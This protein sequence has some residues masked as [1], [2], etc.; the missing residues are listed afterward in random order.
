MRKQG[1]WLKMTRASSEC[2]AKRL[3]C[4]NLLSRVLIAPITFVPPTNDEILGKQYM[5]V[6]AFP[7]HITSLFPLRLSTS[8]RPAHKPH[9]EFDRKEVRCLR[10]SSRQSA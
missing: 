5:P 2:C 9:V 8:P 4:S 7:G 3:V 6:D 10:P 1:F